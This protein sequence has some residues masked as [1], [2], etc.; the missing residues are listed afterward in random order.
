MVASKEKQKGPN[1]SLQVWQFK[2]RFAGYMRD[3]LGDAE[4]F[5]KIFDQIYHGYVFCCLVG[6]VKGR[7]HEYDPKIDNPNNEE[8]LG[9]RWTSAEGSGLYG[10]DML[11]KMVILFDEKNHPDFPTRV[12]YALRF[13]FP[14][15]DVTNEELRNKSKYG[16]NGTIIDEYVLGGLEYIHEKIMDSSSPKDV[17]HFMMGMKEELL[18]VVNTKTE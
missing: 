7:R 4:P 5:Q 8:P 13:D 1:E 17:I 2:G 10:Y 18:E 11:R 14:T 9:F 15:N 16:E 12:D 6:L 3:L